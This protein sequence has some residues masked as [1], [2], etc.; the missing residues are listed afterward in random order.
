[1]GRERPGT[2][3]TG[4]CWATTQT[5][6]EKN[7]FRP[8]EL[9]IG[10]QGEGGRRR[11]GGSNIRVIKEDNCLATRPDMASYDN[12]WLACD[13]GCKSLI[14]T[15]T[16]LPGP[17]P[18]LSLTGLETITGWATIRWWTMV[19]PATSLVIGGNIILFLYQ[20]LLWWPAVL[21]TMTNEF[22]F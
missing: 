21:L 16:L 5:R 1:M 9:S 10:K 4:V 7:F 11:R 14:I 22:S 17:T 8:M 20:L 19:L 3:W 12:G 13:E 18:F 6:L 2:V 15:L